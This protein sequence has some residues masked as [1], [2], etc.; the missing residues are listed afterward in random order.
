MTCFGQSCLFALCESKTAMF[1]EMLTKMNN[2][3]QRLD[4][5]PFPPPCSV[6]TI[7]QETKI[8][9]CS[10][11]RNHSVNDKNVQNEQNQ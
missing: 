3:W 10:V 6:T 11:N 2:T 4:D 9:T 7:H 1:A 8:Y 5:Q